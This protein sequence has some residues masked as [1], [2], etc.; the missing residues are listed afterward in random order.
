MNKWSLFACLAGVLAMGAGC[1]SSVEDV[2]CEVRPAALQ[3]D[4]AGGTESIDV[5]ASV[6][7]QYEMEASAETW[8][9]VTAEAER[10]LVT[11][12]ENPAGDRQTTL[13][14]IPGT[15]VLPVRQVVIAQQGVKPELVIGK[16]EATFSWKASETC[17]I[18]VEAVGG[19]SSWRVEVP[20]E[21]QQWLSVEQQVGF[22][23]L[24]TTADNEQT[25]RTATV[26]VTSS[27]ETV[28]PVT[29]EVRQQGAQEAEPQVHLRTV[30]LL[31]EGGT[32]LA[33]TS[34]R[35]WNGWSFRD[36]QNRVVEP[37][38][39]TVSESRDDAG[40]WCL[41]VTAAANEAAAARRVMLGVS[42]A[43]QDHYVDMNMSITQEG[44]GEGE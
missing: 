35:K 24:S 18:V 21:A 4:R 43:V 22:F 8:L 38:W 17:V 9:T 29:I 7:W 26:R 10:L 36:E 33:M 41:S 16:R 13:R 39:L 14:I 27:D 42:F 15:E 23:V 12:A 3:F 20:A 1:T 37:D 30:N 40:Q 6:A 32:A 44:A 31:A 2:R 11:A 28:E 25:M 34:D 19:V 5:D